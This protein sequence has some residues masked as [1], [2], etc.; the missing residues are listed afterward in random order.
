MYQKDVAAML[1][2]SEETVCY[3]ENGWVKPSQRSLARIIE[4]LDGVDQ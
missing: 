3:W 4:F 1:G 2:V